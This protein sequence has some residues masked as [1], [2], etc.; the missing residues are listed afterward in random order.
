MNAENFGRGGGAV[1][2]FFRARSRKRGFIVTNVHSVG[3][4]FGEGPRRS[5]KAKFVQ[6]KVR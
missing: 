2:I 3:V 1:I 6:L 4:Q 5:E